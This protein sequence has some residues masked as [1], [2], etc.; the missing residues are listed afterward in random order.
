MKASQF[1]LLLF[2]S[3][4]WGA[5]HSLIRI[6]VPE[7]GSA[8]TT[9]LRIG[10]AAVTLTL[11]L[12]MMKKKLNFR[13][14]F[15]QF[16]IVGFLNASFPIFLFAY[17]AKSLPASYL[18]ILNAST[19]IFNAILS[20][21]FLSDPFTIKKILGISLGISGIVMLEQRGTIEHVDS[22]SGFAMACTLL[23]SAC[24]GMSAVY[25]K[26]SE[27]K[28]DPIILTAGSNVIGMMFLFPFA[29]NGD[30]HWTWNAALPSIL[31][32]G[33]LGSGFAFVIYYGLLQKIGAFRASLSTFILPVF[34]L[35][36]SW[37]F[38]DEIPN[39]YMMIGVVLIISATSLFL[40]RDPIQK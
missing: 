7:W 17:A 16:F 32:L 15:K 14:N 40:K 5:S 13:E 25:L 12:M 19:P 28:V 22:V 35:F 10:I 31:I 2:V 33:V 34:G 30:W 4:I 9:F 23:A 29:M 8:I 11:L 20:S 27:R 21:L 36:W 1:L 24:Y 26:K 6:T 38:L 18:V 3:A 37:L 39:A